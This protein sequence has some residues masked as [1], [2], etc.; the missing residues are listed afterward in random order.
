MSYILEEINIFNF[1]IPLVSH[2]I[3]PDTKEFF[4]SRRELQ[5]LNP[6]CGDTT[7]L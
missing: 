6:N 5:L 3:L 4:F 7:N 2:F 1:E